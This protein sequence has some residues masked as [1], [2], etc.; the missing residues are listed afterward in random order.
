MG[1]TA[2]SKNK[3]PIQPIEERQRKIRENIKKEKE[4]ELSSL[5][6]EIS[7]SKGSKMSR[8]K[9]DEED[10]ETSKLSKSSLNQSSFSQSRNF[11]QDGD[12]MGFGAFKRHESGDEDDDLDFQTEKPNKFKWP[13]GVFKKILFTLFLPTHFLYWFLMPNIK[14]RPDISKVLLSS[15]L[16]ILFSIGFAFAIFRLEVYILLATNMKMEF[17]GLING[18]LFGIM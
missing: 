14:R 7:E 13:E 10:E 1:E 17:L 15:I 12:R 8:S 11:S 18:F 4:K 2:S 5:K 3:L 9:I 6:E 16:V